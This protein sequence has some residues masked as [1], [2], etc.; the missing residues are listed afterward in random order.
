MKKITAIIFSIIFALSAFTLVASAESPNEGIMPCYNNV[1]DV[2]ETF[3]IDGSGNAEITVR[4][5]SD[6]GVVTSATIEIKLEKKILFWWSEQDTWTLS[7]TAANY[8]DVINTT[9]K[10]GKYRAEIT[11]T[12]N[13]NGGSADVINKTLEAEY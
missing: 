13:G 11:Y 7:S 12:I 8:T 6:P 10:K 9:V 5:Y 2:R 3:S 1:A 4:Y